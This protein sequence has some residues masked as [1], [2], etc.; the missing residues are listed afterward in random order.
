MYLS[1]TNKNSAEG[2]VVPK[3]TKETWTVGSMLGWS[4]ILTDGKRDPYITSCL[5]QAR[6]KRHFFDRNAWNH[7]PGW[8]VIFPCISWWTHKSQ[9]AG[10]DFCQIFQKKK[11]QKLFFFFLTRF[12]MSEMFLTKTW[13]FIPKL[14]INLQLWLVR[15]WTGHPA[16]KLVIIKKQ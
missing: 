1:Q 8:A 13:I 7:R 16:H 5:R 10:H 11:K 9:L 14:L 4:Q 2:Y 12:P 3:Q 15:K 6:Q